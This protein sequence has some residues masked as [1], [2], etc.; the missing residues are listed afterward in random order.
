MAL[1]GKTRELRD[2]LRAQLREAGLRATMPRVLV[3]EHLRA[4]AAPVSH[5]ELTEALAGQG[6][7]RAT[8]YRNLSDLAEA[9]LLHRTDHGDHVWRYEL[10]KPAESHEGG[11][12]HFV[13]RS[14]GDVQ[15]LPA[16]VVELHHARGVPRSLR[17]RGELEV[18]LRGVC[19]RCA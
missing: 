10:R 2:A 13:C 7:D 5:P 11:H 3:L 16:S 14:C 12:P 8:L 1:P 6:V 15:C 4:A 17:A 19:D 18:H 9:G